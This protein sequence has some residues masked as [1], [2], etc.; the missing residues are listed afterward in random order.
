M[1]ANVALIYAASDPRVQTAV[2]FSPGLNYFG[3]STQ[4]AIEDFD[5]RPSLM[6]AGMDDTNSANT[7]TTL[8]DASDAATTVLVP[9]ATHGAAILPQNPDALEQTLT[10]FSDRL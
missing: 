6:Y 5:P 4:N 1:G 8:G 2:L 3:L 9:G 10:W 7:L